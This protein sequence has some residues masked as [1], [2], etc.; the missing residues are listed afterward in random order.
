MAPADPQALVAAK[1]TVWEKFQAE[2]AKA[3]AENI[4]NENPAA[5]NNAAAGGIAAAANNVAAGNIAAAANNVALGKNV[6]AGNIAAAGNN[7]DG[8]QKGAAEGS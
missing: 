4:G 6:A 8:A 5:G 2:K 1:S 3:Q 7:A